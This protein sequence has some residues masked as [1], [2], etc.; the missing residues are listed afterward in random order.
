MNISFAHRVLLLMVGGFVLGPA[1]ERPAPQQERPAIEKTTQAIILPPP[2][3][4]GG[5]TGGAGGAGVGGAGGGVGGAGMGGAGGGACLCDDG[6]PC[7]V[8][9]CTPTGGCD[10][11]MPSGPNTPCN[12]G[13]LCTTGDTCSGTSCVGTPVVCPTPDQCHTQGVCSPLTG[14]CSNPVKQDGSGCNYDNNACTTDTCQSGVCQA[15]AATVCPTPD[16]CH[17]PGSCNPMTGIC[18][19]PPKGNGSLCNADNNLCT[20]PDTCQSGVCQAGAAVTC[21]A[22]DQCTTGGTCN[23]S[24]GICSGSP[25]PNGTACNDSSAC[26]RTDTCQDGACRGSNP[27]VCTPLDQCH[28]AG[29]C[30]PMTGVCSNPA[31]TDGSGCNDG[32]ACTR[33]DACQGG[34]CRGGN[35]VTCL[36]ANQCRGAGVCD[37]ATGSCSNPP[38]TGSQCNDD[39]PCTYEDTCTSEGACVGKKIVCDSDDTATRTCNGTATCDVVPKPGAACDD[40][41]PCTKGDVRKS[42]GSCAGMA[43]ACPMNECLTANECDGNGG[44]KPTAK[45]D[46]TGCDADKNLCT[47]KDICRGGL[48]VPD[49]KPVTCVAKDCNKATCNPATGNCDYMPTSGGECGLTGCFTSGTCSNGMCSGKPKDCSAM[50]GPCT[51]AA[52]DALTGECVSAPKPNGTACAAGGKCSAGAICAFGTCELAPMACPA[53]SAPCKLPACDPGTG[54]C[55]EQNRKPGAPC[56]PKNSCMTEAACD[57]EGNCIGAPAPNGDPCTLAGGKVGRCAL[58]ACMP[59]GDSIPAGGNLPKSDASAADGPLGAGADAGATLS[60]KGGCTCTIGARSTGA[61]PLLLALGALGRVMGRRRRQS[62]GRHEG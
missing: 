9:A 17:D 4:L 52:C 55:V 51:E 44:C 10:F 30:N 15:G 37:P 29:A 25:K 21:G 24:T 32:N 34:T 54:M 12:D 42:D 59:A 7:T 49:P 38:K 2:D 46:G 26:T 5:C 35:P 45:P 6:N 14:T 56:D 48:C 1:C 13:S 57:S 39:M 28:N 23:P 58:G 47:P 36:A 53:A 16:Q 27:V 41:N 20:G 8:N 43:Y 3:C 11:S 19:N 60:G 62:R 50:A 61:T 33:T 22:S 18:S 40:G 31:K